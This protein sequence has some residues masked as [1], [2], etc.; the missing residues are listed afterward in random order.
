MPWTVLILPYIDQA[1]LYNQFN[2]SFPFFGRNDHQTPAG[3]PNYPLQLLDSPPGFRCPSNPVF[4][5]D[6]YVNCYNAC[7]GGGGPA[8]KTDPA[9]GNPAVDGTSPQSASTD[10]LPFSSNPMMPCYN[11]TRPRFRKRS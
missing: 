2:A 11:R 9:T 5:S 7:M 8:F 3:S 1:P 10:N 4:N 6:K